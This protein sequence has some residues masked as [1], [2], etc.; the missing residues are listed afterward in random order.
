MAC[1]KKVC[2]VKIKSIVDGVVPGSQAYYDKE[3]QKA[4]A[5]AG[6][7]AE[8]T[9]EIDSDQ[10]EP[11][12]DQMDDLSEEIAYPR[13]P[14]RIPETWLT[15]IRTPSRF[16]IKVDGSVDHCCP[17]ICYVREFDDATDC[18]RELLPSGRKVMILCNSG[19]KVRGTAVGMDGTKDWESDEMTGA[20]LVLEKCS[21]Q[22]QYKTKAFL[23]YVE[24]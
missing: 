13:S 14:V 19:V 10:Q 1:A 15:F 9:Q 17:V 4:L 24:L 16:W 6:I 12:L 11:D 22:L 5:R 23:A 7:E 2:P 21:Y 3:F 20:Y 18:Y 8:A